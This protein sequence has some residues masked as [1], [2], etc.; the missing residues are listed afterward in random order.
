MVELSHPPATSLRR[1]IRSYVRREGRLTPAQRRALTELW[2]RYGLATDRALEM[3][4]AFPARQPVILEI[5]F[6]NGE[7]LIHLAENHPQFNYL[8]IEVHRPGVGHL[9]LKLERAGLTNVRV[10]CADAVGILQSVLP[11]R[12]LHRINIFFPDPWPKKRHHKRRLI[13]P[14]FVR[15][16]SAVLENEGLLHLATD[17]PDYAEHM[18]QVLAGFTEFDRIDHQSVIPPRPPSKYERRGRRL[19]HPVIDLVYRKR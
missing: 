10:F 5:G 9:L 18:Q 8:G 6:G 16:L 19:G 11:E 7:S 3:E 12:S 4:R 13:Q 2:P 15:L 14:G 17:W 1:R